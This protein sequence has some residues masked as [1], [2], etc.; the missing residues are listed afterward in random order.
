LSI[1]LLC[2]WLFNFLRSLYILDIYLLN[3]WGGLSPILWLVSWF[4]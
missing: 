4:W 1:G 2:V 3:S